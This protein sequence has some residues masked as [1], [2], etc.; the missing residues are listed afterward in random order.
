MKPGEFEIV[1]VLWMDTAHEPGWF[2]ADHPQRS[3][4]GTLCQSTGFLVARGPMGVTLAQSTGG[5]DASLFSGDDWGELLHIHAGAILKL[6]RI[7][8]VRLH[9]RWRYDERGDSR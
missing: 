3:P 1:Y 5:H 2:S 6:R 4:E 8:R 9:R 7:A